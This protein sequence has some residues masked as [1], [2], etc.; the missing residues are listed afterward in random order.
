MIKQTNEEE[1]FKK[2]NNHIY[3][4]LITKCNDN[5][6]SEIQNDNE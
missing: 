4:D 6:N 5:K 3:L 1:K 2:K